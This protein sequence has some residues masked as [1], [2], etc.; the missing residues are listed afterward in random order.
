MTP[1]TVVR[2]A[3]AAYEKYGF[4]DFKLKGGVLAGEEEAES[5]V[6]LAKRFPQ[7]R[8]TLDPNGAWSLN[9]AIS[10]GKLP[11][12]FSGLCRRSVRRGTGFFRA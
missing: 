12:R 5:I 6:A 1:E 10:I 8:V 4:N 11:E 3:E 7:A 9:E 2:L